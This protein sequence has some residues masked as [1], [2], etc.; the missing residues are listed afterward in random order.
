MLLQATTVLLRLQQTQARCV[1]KP[2]P[3]RERVYTYDYALLS[4]TGHYI[5]CVCVHIYI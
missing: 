3:G 2:K 4:I 5:P 1:A